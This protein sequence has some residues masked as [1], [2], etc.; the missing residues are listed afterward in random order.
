M[1]SIPYEQVYQ[2][3]EEKDAALERLDARIAMTEKTKRVKVSEAWKD[4]KA[5]L[6]E[7]KKQLY[8][9][10]LLVGKSK[11]GMSFE[12]KGAEFIAI[13]SEIRQLVS[14]IDT[15]DN[16]EKNLENLKEMRKSITERKVAKEV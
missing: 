14:L 16:A 15:F 11:Q 2:S 9:I 3:Q 12:D 8:I 1:G 10:F 13:Q 6:E 4:I 7:R 5:E